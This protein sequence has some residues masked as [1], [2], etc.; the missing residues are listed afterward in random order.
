MGDS[1]TRSTSTTWA[2]KVVKIRRPA[3]GHSDSAPK[4]HRWRRF[5]RRDPKDWI[6][7]RVK[8]SG[9]SS[10]WV[11]VQGRGETNVYPADT[12]LLNV[13]LDVNQCH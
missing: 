4:A 10:G 13:V 3:G 6:T 9:G 2:L 8:Y 1:H 11:V 7:L 5:P 12:W